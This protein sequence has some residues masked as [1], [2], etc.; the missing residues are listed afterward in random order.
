MIV[1]KFGG[2]SLAS[3]TSIG[4]VVSIVRAEASRH[5]VIV[6]S[7]MGDTTDSLLAILSA[8][9]RADSYS[10]WRLQEAVKQQHF[11]V[12]EELLHGERQSAIDQYLRDTYRDLHVRMLELS[13][14][15]R[16]FTPELQDW[17]IS[18]GEQLSSRLVAAVL[19]EHCGN[20]IHLDARKLILTDDAFT[21]AQPRYWET[22]AH[23]RWTIPLAARDNL[24]VLGGFIGSTEEGRTTTLGRG[25]SDL[26][27]SIVGAAINAEEIQVWKDVDGML[28]CDPRLF[29]GGYRVKRLSYKEA[30]ELA[31]AGATILHPETMMPAKRLRIPI[32]IRNTFR[33]ASDGTTIG[34]RTAECANVLK[35]IAIKQNITL[36][37]VA[38]TNP[39]EDLQAL[40]A[41][42]QQ[43]SSAATML[44]SSSSA[45]YIALDENAKLSEQDLAPDRCRQVR[46][47]TQQ[48]ILTLVGHVADKERMAQNLAAA[49][50]GVP[51][52]VLTGSG[53]DCSIRLAVPQ[54]DLKKCLALLHRRVF[55]NP[56][57][58]FFVAGVSGDVRKVKTKKAGVA[59]VPSQQQPARPRTFGLSSSLLHTN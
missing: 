16:A 34:C 23:I 24:V 43:N 26:T 13:E 42:C 36:L 6:A 5:P 52:L 46:M 14:G 44:C 20:T 41:L 25:G 40:T 11:A 4:R 28:T 50:Q 47:R 3:P 9:R 27:A 38:S 22:Y 1:M 49:L 29:K 58:K 54:A 32:V 31:Q 21:N 57:P 12:C 48:A 55:A 15:E 8:A 37:E 7:A 19:G 33:P 30:S 56:D 35:S 18:L 51:N 2:S 10:V 39:A 45:V 17:T 53:S 59:R